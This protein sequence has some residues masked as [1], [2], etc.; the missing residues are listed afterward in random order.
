M[1]YG[2]GG[3]KLC[4]KEGGGGSGE[5]ICLGEDLIGG[6]VRDQNDLGT[7]S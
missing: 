7:A 3:I 4:S 5:K 1:G 2:G 6:D